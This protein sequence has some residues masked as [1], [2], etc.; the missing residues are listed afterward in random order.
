V[1]G[2]DQA[3]PSCFC[4]TRFGVESGEPIDAIVVRKERERLANG[5]VFLWGIGN[6]I[7][8]ALADLVNSVDEPEVL[9]SPIHSRPRHV[10]ASPESVAQ[11]TSAQGLFGEDFDLPSQAYVV[12][13][14]NPAKPKPAHYALVCGSVDPLELGDQGQL[15]VSSLRNLRSGA[16]VGASQVTAVVRTSGEAADGRS[17]RV[18][19]RTALVAPYFVRLK[20]PV[21]L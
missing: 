8:P 5:G 10:D 12:S 19:M 6:S 13:R 2:R 17:Y 18:A 11:W 16:I 14:W 21:L 20:D 15:H 7:A 3:L 9:F 1:S 4:W